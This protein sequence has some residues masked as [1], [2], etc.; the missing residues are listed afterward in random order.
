M[1]VENYAWH[2]GGGGIGGVI[3]L[4]VNFAP[5]PAMAQTSLSSV[6]GPGLCFGGIESYRTRPDPAGPEQTTQYQWD[7]TFGFPPV[8]FDNALSS[9]SASLTLGGRQYGCL[10]LMVSLWR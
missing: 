8:V 5:Q 4:Q 7:P 2:W 9:V 6:S 3:N 1:G 10:T